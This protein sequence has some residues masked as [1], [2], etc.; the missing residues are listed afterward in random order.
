MAAKIAADLPPWNKME[1]HV[2]CMI[3]PNSRRREPDMSN[4]WRK[5]AWLL[6]LLLQTAVTAAPAAELHSLQDIV[7]QASNAAAELAQAQGHAD[8]Q[9]SARPLDNRLRLAACEQPLQTFS[10]PNARTLGPVSI[11]VRCDSPQAWTIYVRLDVSSQVTLP[12][13]TTA[14]PR[15]TIISAQDLELVTRPLATDHGVIIVDA[16]HIIGMELTRAVPAGTPLRHNQLRPPQLIE[17]GQTVVLVAGGDGLQVSMQGKAM[18]SAAAGDRL[19]V[20]NLASG[21]RVEGIVNP[22]GSVSIR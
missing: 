18:A 19:L 12:V 2:S 21:R 7:L 4:L 13:P 16:E 6:A 11:G 3:P 20:T 14:L 1:W 15:G 5:P 8:P 9:V 22:D 10:S 17:R